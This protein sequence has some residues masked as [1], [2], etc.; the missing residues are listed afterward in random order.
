[1][2]GLLN[3]VVGYVED[4]FLNLIEFMFRHWDGFKDS[5]KIMEF[6]NGDRC[7]NDPDR[8]LKVRFALVFYV[9]LCSFMVS[10]NISLLSLESISPVKYM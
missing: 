6:S 5:Y 1:M 2:V 9:G 10:K 3:E 7:W 8:S 4:A